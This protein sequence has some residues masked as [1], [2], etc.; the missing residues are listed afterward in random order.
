LK[1]FGLEK[2]LTNVKIHKIFLPEMHLNWHFKKMYIF[3][4]K[5]PIKCL[6]KINLMKKTEGILLL[7]ITN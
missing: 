5:K 3:G 2:V 6:K 7:D 1:D 4:G